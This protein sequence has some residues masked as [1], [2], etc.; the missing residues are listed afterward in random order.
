MRNYTLKEK[1]K[2]TVDG[3]ICG[4]VISDSLFDTDPMAYLMCW[5]MPDDKFELYKNET[6]KKKKSALFDKYAYSHI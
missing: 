5:T 2:S 6:N 4:G 3:A 1:L